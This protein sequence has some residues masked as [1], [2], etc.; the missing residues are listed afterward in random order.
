MTETELKLYQ[1]CA[2]QEFLS[3][4]NDLIEKL[5]DPNPNWTY[6]EIIE[7]VDESAESI[8]KLAEDLR[9]KEITYQISKGTQ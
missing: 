9:I 2:R 7:M 8:E 1:D 4:V 3:I 6:D 5:E